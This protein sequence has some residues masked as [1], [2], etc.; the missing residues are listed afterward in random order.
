VLPAIDL[1]A[2]GKIDM[3]QLA[4]H[5]FP[6]AETQDAFDMVANYRDGVIKAII[7]VGGSS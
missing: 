7:R 3:E 2:T 1:L 5:H 6:L 4:T